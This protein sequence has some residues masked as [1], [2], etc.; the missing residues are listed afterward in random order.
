VGVALDAAGDVW[1]ANSG[2]V[3]GVQTVPAN[4]AEVSAGGVPITLAGGFASAN[5]MGV[6]SLALDGSGN[7]W[8]GSPAGL[9]EF[10]PGGIETDVNVVATAVAMDSNGNAWVVNGSTATQVAPGGSVAS[11]TA[12]DG[13]SS[14]AKAVAVGA[15][16]VW[17]AG[18]SAIDAMDFTGALQTPPGG[19]TGGGTNGPVGMAVDGYESV[20][21]ANA[22]SPC[23]S[24]FLVDGTVQSP[25]TGYV[26][27]Y[28]QRPTGIG[29][30]AS[31]NVWVSDAANG[32]VVFV[33]L[34]NPTVTPIALAGKNGTL[35]MLP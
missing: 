2:L 19:L 25:G 30:D 3:A 20:Y 27:A 10:S 6:S 21:V 34:G 5:L 32:A 28:L 16:Y 26:S 35:G 12:I 15:Q 11:M 24:E 31:G 33:G 8:A 14:G 9:T 29:V 23:V 7:A 4:L 18:T 1:T 13:G 22:G 17:A